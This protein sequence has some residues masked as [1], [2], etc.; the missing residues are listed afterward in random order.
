MIPLNSFKHLD[1]ALREIS[2]EPTNPAKWF[3]QQMLSCLTVDSSVYTTNLKKF[4]LTVFYPSCCTLLR[5]VARAERTRSKLKRGQ[6]E[7][8][9]RSSQGH[10]QG[11]A[12]WVKRF[13]FF[14]PRAILGFG[15]FLGAWWTWSD[16]V[17]WR[18]DKAQENLVGWWQRVLFVMPFYC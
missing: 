16:K 5:E 10:H 17:G 11:H 6:S 13:F 2:P 3:P 14:P 4:L 15:F 8:K 12:L 18:R 1:F 9:G 7:E